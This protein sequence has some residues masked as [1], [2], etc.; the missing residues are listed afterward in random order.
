MKTL[1]LITLILFLSSNIFSLNADDM[2]IAKRISIQSAVLDEERAIFISTPSGYDP[3]WTYY[4]DVY[5]GTIINS[6]NNK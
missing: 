5:E 1:K 4:S 6:L 3:D 2:V